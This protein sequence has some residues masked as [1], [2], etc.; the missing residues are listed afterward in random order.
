MI[1][2]MKNIFQKSHLYIV[3][4][5][6]LMAG[7]FG[8]QADGD[9][10]QKDTHANAGYI[11]T[12]VPF[13]RVQ[14]NDQFWKPRLETQARTL[15]PFALEKT[16]PAVENLRK[17]AKYLQG[18]TTQLPFPHRFV[19]SDLYKVMEGASYLLM[20]NRNPELE[21]QLDDIID[22]IAAAQ[23]EDGYLYEAHITGVS[24]NHDHFTGGGMGDKPYS[25]VVHSHELYNMGH[26]YEA[27][28][29]YYQATGKDKWLK[30]AEKNAQHIN[31][32]FFEGD[33]NYNNGKPVNQAPGH[34]EPELALAKLYRFTNNELYLKMA[35]KFLDIRGVTYVPEGEGVMAPTYAQQHKPVAE[36]EKAVGHAVRAAYL[37]S[38]MADV[39]ALMHTDE[40]NQALN[41]IWH[42]IVDTKM[43]ITGGL[44]AIRG[45]EGF[46]PE[47][48]LPNKEAYNETCAAVGNVFFNFRMFLL[49]QDAK[50]MDVAEVALLNNALAGT[51]FE[52][53]RFFYVNPLEADGETPF[54]HGKPGRS[55]WFNT[56]C[57]P[58]NLARLIPQVSGMMYTHTDNEVFITFYASN[59]TTIGLKEGKVDLIQ[60]ANYPFDG[61]I[62]IVINPSKSQTF[63]LNLR[64]P[65]WARTNQFLPG[66]LYDFSGSAEIIPWQVKINGEEI[67][68]QIDKGF[69]KIDRTWNSGDKVELMLPMPVRFNTAIPQVEEDKNRIAI[70]RGPLVYCAEGIDNDVAVQ[71][72]FID[73]LPEKSLIKAYPFEEGIL[74]DVV[75]IEIPAK[76]V[77][78]GEVQGSKLI[79]IPY[80]AWDNRVDGTMMVWLPTKK[81]MVNF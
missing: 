15:V 71:H 55:P 64:I 58:S 45:I 76:K 67:K 22:I 37:Y 69:V 60:Q 26:M 44:G 7:F 47:Y 23:Q 17:T 53:N 11:L 77:S 62:E 40:Y 3:V 31:R 65:T 12:P 13:N 34:E 4:L 9:E 43:H 66:E 52:G 68:P 56:A 14:L 51:N 72:F 29:A 19:A 1:T 33:P 38:G 24:K 30:V 6:V 16:K 63:K 18:D 78:G 59:S 41:D 32:V 5:A 8:C 50:F 49:T 42:N 48:D 80:Y 25:W 21:K 70:T 20:E 28:I 75:K 74:E 73:H 35:K 2:K 27:A 46:G 39:G 10:G 36:Q 54:N 79:M 57:C 61:R 81:E